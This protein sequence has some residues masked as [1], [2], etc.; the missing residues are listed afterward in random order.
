M[1]I[2][3]TEVKALRDATG[4]GMMD[5]KKALIDAAG[6]VEKAKQ[7]LREKGQAR[8]GKLSERSAEEGVV[9]ATLRPGPGAAQVGVLLELNCA[10]DFVAKTERFTDLASDLADLAAEHKPADV[11]ALLALAF[12]G[13]T[14]SDVL[15]STSSEVGEPIRIRRFQRFETKTG[16]VD[17]YLH[18]PDPSLPPKV[19]VLVEIE[20]GDHAALA[21]PAREVCLHIAAMRPAYVSRDQIPADEV[22]KERQVIEAQSRSEG[23]PEAVLSKIV[24]GRL[25]S[26][27]EGL[28]LLD[29]PY[30]RDDKQSVAKFLGSAKVTQFVRYRVG[31][32]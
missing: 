24:E 16:L 18:Q 28:A 30:V 15:T 7:I 25:K 6:D 4:A 19:G 14:V 8:A 1:E 17:A 10:T 32:E 27:Y 22:E 31:G 23:K 9:A 11:D 13:K 21:T 20:G 3:A 12:Q 5:A 29:Q 2:K 26:F